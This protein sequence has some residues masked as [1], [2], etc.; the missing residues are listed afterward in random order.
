[1]KTINKED[2]FIDD[3]SVWVTRK[4][5]AIKVEAMS[6]LHILNTIRAW[7][8]LG[9]TKPPKGYMGG[10]LKWI[11]T[12]TRELIKRENENKSKNM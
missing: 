1:M 12:L 4:K 7:E 9:I 3:G 5:K 8:G 10:K 11:D 2:W 6:T